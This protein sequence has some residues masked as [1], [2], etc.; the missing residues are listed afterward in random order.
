MRITSITK[1]NSRKI[2]FAVDGKP[3]FFLNV[4]ELRENGQYGRVIG[5]LGP[6]GKSDELDIELDDLLFEKIRKEI[7]IPRGKRYA[8]SLLADRD[9]TEK[10]LRDK[11]KETGYNEDDRDEIIGYLKEKGFLDDLRYA[12]S[13]I[14]LAIKTK[15]RRYICGKLFEK[16]VSDDTVK[17]AF[18]ETETEFADTGIN[19]EELKFAALDRQIEKVLERTA[20]DDRDSLTKAIQSLM[21]K[22]FHYSEIKQR[23]E[24][25]YKT[26]QE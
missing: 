24:N 21:R 25:Y 3:V 26:G 5:L 15:S 10:K 8:L 14:R 17:Q 22:G 19:S 18:E 12:K 23:I 2:R 6:D 9:Y 13:Y 16:G 11:L 1:E 20:A 7:I 4:S